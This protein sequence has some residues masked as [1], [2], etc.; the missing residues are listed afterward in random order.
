MKRI[1][2]RWLLKTAG[3]GGLF[4]HKPGGL[5]PESA[6]PAM[7]HDGQWVSMIYLDIVEF[8]LT[9][10]VSG[11][12]ICLRVLQ[13]LESLARQEAPHHLRPYRLLEVRR[14]GDDLLIYFYSKTDPPPDSSDLA[15]LSLSFRDSLSSQ[16]NRKCSHLV[17]CNINFHVGYTIIKPD[18]NPENSI[19]TAFKEAM[20]I[21]KSQLDVKEV[22]RRRQFKDLLAQ[23]NISIVYQPVVNLTTGEILGYEALSR[24]PEGS[25]FASPLNLFD[26]AQKTHHH[27]QKQALPQPSVGP[28]PAG[29]INHH[30]AGSGPL[31]QPPDRPAR[32]SQD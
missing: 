2:A 32:Q 20:L 10:Q 26:Y 24:G 18:Q 7:L 11:P 25:F 27:H 14:W 13:S 1:L 3:G 19:Y 31:C 22:E 12:S 8:A 5:A 9:E 17:P 23:K 4:S 30:A 21:A 15:N 16:L 28:R 6:V 29:R